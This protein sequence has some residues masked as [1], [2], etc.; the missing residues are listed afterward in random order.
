MRKVL[1]VVQ[2]LFL[3]VFLACAGYIAKYFYD[4]HKAQSD[5][6]ELQ[7]IV[8]ETGDGESADD[9]TDS[10]EKPVAR[11]S[12]GMLQKY[13]ELYQQNEDIVG[14]VSVPGTD[15]DYPVMYKADNNDYYLHRNFKKEYQYSGL[16]FLDYQC[17]LAEP[18]A[19]LIIY[20]HNMKDGTMFAPLTEYENKSYYDSHKTIK[21]DTMYEE[22]EYEIFG[23]FSTT[24]GADD[25]F[26]YHEF[27]NAYTEDEFYGYVNKVK[28]LSYYDTGISAIFGDQLLTLSTCSYGTS[29]ERFVIVAKRKTE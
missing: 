23:A 6:A 15:I 4:S 9:G 28:E 11:A 16:P 5:I 13:Y 18:S 17:N 10:G 1:I 2:L 29:N 3:C 12:N 14:W 22:A 24:V 19:N 20:A 27:V 21:F 25:E 26:R 7:Q 8:D